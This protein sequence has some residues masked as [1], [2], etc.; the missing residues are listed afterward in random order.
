MRFWSRVEQ[1]P[2]IHRTAFPRLCATCRHID[3]FG[4]FE[5]ARPPRSVGN[6]FLEPI[7]MRLGIF[8]HNESKQCSAFYKAAEKVQER[9]ITT[10]EKFRIERRYKD[11]GHGPSRGID[12]DG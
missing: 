11:I 1:K 5:S 12:D 8:E 10:K 7:H 3:E 6:S 2:L 9:N 4:V